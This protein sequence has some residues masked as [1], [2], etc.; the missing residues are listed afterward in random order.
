LAAYFRLSRLIGVTLPFSSIVARGLNALSRMGSVGVVAVAFGLV[1][2][3]FGFVAVEV[4]VSGG[5]GNETVSVGAERTGA[6]AFAGA[7]V[8]D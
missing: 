5:A 7:T 8:V 2:E 1:V 3:A 4:F 6:D